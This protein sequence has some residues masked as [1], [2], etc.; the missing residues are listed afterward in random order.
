MNTF[1]PKDY[2]EPETPS[3]YMRFREGLNSFRIMSQPLMYLE[4]WTE[5]KKPMRSEEGFESTP[6][7]KEG[8]QIKACWGFVVWNNMAYKNKKGDWQ[9]MIQI[10]TIHQKTIK[11][12]IKSLEDNP[13]WGSV[14][15]YDIAVTRTTVGDKTTYQVQAE[16]PIG[17]PSDEIKKAFLAKPCDLKELLK[18]GG[19]PFSK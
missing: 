6:N 11:N 3:N 19:E 15:N 17:E 12:G 18:A 9:G 16:P 7:I 14:F 8:E 4:Y 10:L 1:L 13:K 5:D 2:Q